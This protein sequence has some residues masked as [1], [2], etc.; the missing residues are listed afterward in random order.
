M[1]EKILPSIK[2]IKLKGKDCFESQKYRVLINDI[3]FSSYV[4]EVSA[5]LSANNTYITEVTLKLITTDFHWIDE[6]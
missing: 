3:D 2:V 6:E 4:S 5:S 1:N